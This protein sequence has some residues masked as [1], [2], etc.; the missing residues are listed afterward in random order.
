[1]YPVEAA[2]ECYLLVGSLLVFVLLLSI[3]KKKKNRSPPG[4]P[5]WPIIGNLLQLGD[6]PHESLYRLAQKHGDLMS[7]KLGNKLILVVSSPSMAKEVLKTNDQTFSSRSVTIAAKTF[8]Y[9]G[10]TLVFVHYGP[11]W[12]FLRKICTTELF[13]PKRLDALQHLRKE[14]VN[15][16]IESIF[17]DSKKRQSVNIGASAFVTSLSL[18]ARMVWIELEDEEPR[19]AIRLFDS[20]IE[21]RLQE[22]EA[23][24]HDS[25]GEGKDFLEIMLDLKKGGTQF[26]L[27]DIK[28]MLMDMFVAGTD[29]TSA[30]VEWAMAE[31]IRKPTLLKKA[32]EE[33]DEVVGREKRM[34][35]SDIAKFPYL[36]AVVKEVLRLHPAAPLII[37]RRADNS[38][39]IGGY[40]VPENTQ[41]S[42]NIWGIGRDPNVWKEPLKFKPE[43][44]LDCNT[45]YRGQDFELIPFG[46]GR[47]ICLGLP[48]A[49]RMVHFFLGS[50]L[51]AFNWC[52][53]MVNKDE[54]FGVDMSEMFGI[55]LQKAV[56]LI[57]VP[58]PRLPIK[59]Y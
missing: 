54:Y 32:Q 33:L 46:A 25:C 20:I 49:H 58:T 39:E 12:R 16:T 57:A 48:L 50:L 26:T 56:P 11:Q 17:E 22:K 55:T 36:Q 24:V 15:R 42:V 4:P 27:E 35:E 43:M 18:V 5:G 1:M 9:Q 7:L 19:K 34:E 10:K 41:V 29:T 14:E 8:A 31:L 47:R 13:S 6:R 2:T 23:G 45:D 30:T 53:P 59:L 38:V 52:I 40:V 37:P 3:K 51:H 21:E 28:G 44:F